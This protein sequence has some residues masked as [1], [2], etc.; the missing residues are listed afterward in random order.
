MRSLWHAN[1]Q[2]LE[3]VQALLEV[4]GFFDSARPLLQ[5]GKVQALVGVLMPFLEAAVALDDAFFRQALCLFCILSKLLHRFN[6]HW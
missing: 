2:G 6:L 1:V 3:K 4:V 5:F